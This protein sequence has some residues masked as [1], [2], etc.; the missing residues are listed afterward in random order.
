MKVY[1]LGSVLRFYWEEYEVYVIV[2]NILNIVIFLCSNILFWYFL[3]VN[4]IGFYLY[5]FVRCLPVLLYILHRLFFVLYLLIHPICFILGHRS[6]AVSIFLCFICN[7]SLHKY[8]NIIFSLHIWMPAD[9][10]CSCYRITS[11][12]C[13][14]LCISRCTLRFTLFCHF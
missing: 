5:I 2:D 13:T 8:F 12:S 1:V 7:L 11:T 10:H 14:S 3:L 6:S 9:L 4:A